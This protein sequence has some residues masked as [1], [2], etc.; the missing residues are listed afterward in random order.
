MWLELR[1]SGFTEW[2]NV[3]LTTIDRFVLVADGRE[4]D[5]NG[6]C[7]LLVRQVADVVHLHYVR[8]CLV[9]V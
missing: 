6:L 7:L 3:Y 1:D 4:A 5:S 8:L 9:K 2:R